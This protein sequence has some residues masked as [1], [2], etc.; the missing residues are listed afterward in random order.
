M[1]PQVSETS[2]YTKILEYGTDDN[3]QILCVDMVLN[4][5]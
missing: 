1:D 5:D 4:L 3:Q 2:L